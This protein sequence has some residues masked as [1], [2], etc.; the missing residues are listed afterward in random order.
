MV[1]SSH[2]YNGFSGNG[3]YTHKTRGRLRHDVAGLKNSTEF[4]RD[5]EFEFSR[6]E[7]ILHVEANA[8]TGRI[9]LLFEPER[10]T[11]DELIRDIDTFKPSF[12]KKATSLKDSRRHKHG[13]GIRVKHDCKGGAD[14]ANAKSTSIVKGLV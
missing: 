8:V 14:A 5:V 1:F 9:L 6:K 2:I 11:H 3:T 10:V 13:K 12:N 4:V 7:G